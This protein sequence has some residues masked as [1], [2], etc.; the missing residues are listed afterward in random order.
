MNSLFSRHPLVMQT[1]FAEIKRHGL[2]Q[3]FL[4]VGTPGSV[5]LREVKEQQFYYRQ[6]YNAQGK[7]SAEYIG[8]LANEQVEARVA[9]IRSQ[10]ELTKGLIKESRILV[11]QGYVRTDLRTGAILAALVN[12]ALF[13]AGATLIG[14]HAF[15]ALLN[16]LGISAAAFHTE[17]VDIARN[18]PLK[19]AL[20]PDTDFLQLLRESTIP[21]NPIPG[22]DRKAP[23]TSYKPPGLDR[24]HVDLL[25]PADGL[26]ISIKEVPELKA[27]ATALPFLRYLLADPIDTIVIARECI[28]PV[29]VPRSERFVWHKM[30]VSQLRTASNEKR[31]KDI[32]Q[33]AVIFAALA[34]DAP[35]ALR[36]AFEELP[37]SAKSK[38]ITGARQTLRLLNASPHEQA[39]EFLATLIEENEAT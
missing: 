34:E 3:A 28:A 22:L 10:I 17:D 18:M 6:F 9:A 23:S 13:T 14:S 26:D 38:T 25:V 35:D 2:E 16:E 7:K 19:L 4:L 37:A 31:A 15:G 24:L 11:Q 36:D 5:G 27:H 33:A 32:Q 39:A 8:A 29:K 20:P 1:S 30:L 21:L 12:N